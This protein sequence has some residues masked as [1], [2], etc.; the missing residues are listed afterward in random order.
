VAD[1]GIQWD[2]D[3]SEDEALPPDISASRVK[4]GVSCSFYG[5]SQRLTVLNEKWACVQKP[6]DVGP[7]PNQDIVDKVRQF[8][9]LLSYFVDCFYSS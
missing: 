7:C 3:E 1:L 9:L 6:E 8:F 2:V 5:I 4:S